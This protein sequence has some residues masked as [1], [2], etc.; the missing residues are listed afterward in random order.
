MVR[1]RP[2]PSAAG[3]DLTANRSGVSISS[4]PTR[5]QRTHCTNT[6]VG[7]GRRSTKNSPGSVGEVTNHRGLPRALHRGSSP[8]ASQDS[9]SWSRRTC[10]PP[11]HFSEDLQA[12]RDQAASL[13][14]ALLVWDTCSSNRCFMQGRSAC[15]T[16]VGCLRE[17]AV[18]VPA[19]DLDECAH[20]CLAHGQGARPRVGHEQ[21]LD[22]LRDATGASAV[23][24]SGA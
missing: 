5:G 17:Q 4:A 11:P 24:C 22:Q 15:R 6:T 7:P 21:K 1:N 10:W 9:S 3:E 8:R 18:C 19:L 20:A 12:H 2:Q 14:P 23:G 16:V 13:D